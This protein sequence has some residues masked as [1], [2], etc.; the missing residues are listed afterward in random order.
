MA[1]GKALVASD[2]GGHKELIQHNKTGL[3]FS[4]GDIN[5]LVDCLQQ[6]INDQALMGTL[7]INGTKWVN[8]NHTWDR[9]T[10]VYPE[11]YRKVIDIAD[12]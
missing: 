7:K 12:R 1:M 6:L 11:L 10:S 4:S 2:V 9:T 5:G 3:L 8:E